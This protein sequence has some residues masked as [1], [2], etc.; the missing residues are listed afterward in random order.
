MQ[1]RLFLRTQGR[2][3][4][5][6]ESG[7][8]VL[9]GPQSARARFRED[10]GVPATVGRGSATLDQRLRLQIIKQRNKIGR[11]DAERLCEVRLASLTEIP[12]Q[13]QRDDMPRTH[14]ERG[15]LRLGG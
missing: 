7:E 15:E 2:E 13:G 3:H 1:S 5:P 11:I 9:H 4:E 6:L 14:V 10:D 12:E 8:R